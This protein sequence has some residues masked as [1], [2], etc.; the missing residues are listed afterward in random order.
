MKKTFSFI[1]VFA[2]VLV[3]NL[4]FAQNLSLNE[5][6]D[7]RKKSLTEYTNYLKSKDWKVEEKAGL[8]ANDFGG[9]G[10]DSFRLKH[11]NSES[12]IDYLIN[13]K[14]K[15]ILIQI[16][17]KDVYSQYLSK[18]LST[19]YLLIKSGLENGNIVKVYQGKKNS[20]KVTLASDKMNYSTE[21]NTT[22]VFLIMSNE[23]YQL[24]F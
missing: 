24:N 5:L 21:S 11:N 12:I 10:L 9:K 4:G 20:V 15:R 8:S 14:T 3:A 2:F 18:L 16:R 1:A 7:L 13:K 19:G 17:Q 6:I 22:F 23:D